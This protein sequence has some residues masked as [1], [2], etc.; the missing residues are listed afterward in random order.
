[1]N[2]HEQCHLQPLPQ[3]Q[4][5]IPSIPPRSQSAPLCFISSS[6]SSHLALHSSFVQLPHSP[7]PS[8]R[9]LPIDLNSDSHR[10]SLLF[11]QINRA[12]EHICKSRDYAALHSLP[13]LCHF[14]GWI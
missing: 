4:A 10:L 5:V 12:T 2:C 6:L 13:P 1:M 9:P 3:Q 7:F 11:S 8:T 14:Y